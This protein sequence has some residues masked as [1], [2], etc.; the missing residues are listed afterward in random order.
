MADGQHQ[1]SHFLTFRMIFN[2]SQYLNHDKIKE[3]SLRKVR[4][5]VKCNSLPIKSS[6]NGKIL[7][8]NQ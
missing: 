8:K 4:F 3:K 7:T 5:F 2:Y 1:V 6:K